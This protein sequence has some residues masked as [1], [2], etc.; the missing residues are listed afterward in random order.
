MATILTA[1]A[2]P[3]GTDSLL[4]QVMANSM[5]MCENHHSNQEL[6]GQGI[7]KIGNAFFGCIPCNAAI[8]KTSV[9]I[10]SS[11]KTWQATMIDDVMLAISV[12]SEFP[13][14]A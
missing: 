13:G 9:N 4:Y 10:R 8:I 14:S 3:S 2:A 1:I 11:G 12:P 5:I 7:A 6:F